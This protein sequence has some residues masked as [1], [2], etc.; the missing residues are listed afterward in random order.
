M[1]V[2]AAI[3]LLLV[4]G[5]APLKNE[6]LPPPGTKIT[7]SHLPLSGDPGPLTPLEVTEHVVTLRRENSMSL[8][9]VYVQ[10]LRRQAI[11]AQEGSDARLSVCR[12]TVNI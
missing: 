11:E 8:S 6:L 3:L 12:R 1:A 10:A 7:L 9:S 4:T 5:V 2:V